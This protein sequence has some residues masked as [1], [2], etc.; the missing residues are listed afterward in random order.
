MEI[1]PNLCPESGNPKSHAQR[2]KEYYERLKAN[3]E[4][5][6]ARLDK[7]KLRSR[8]NR[9]IFRE[10][11]TEEE[12]EN[13]RRKNRERLQRWRQRKAQNAESERTFE[14]AK[15]LTQQDI[16]KLKQKREREKERRKAARAA[17]STQRRITERKKAMDRYYRRKS[18]NP[19]KKS[20]AQATLKEDKALPTRY[21]NRL[22][23]SYICGVLGDPRGI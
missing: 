7:Q 16:E 3:E 11:A 1:P 18:K 10:Q 8:I 4:L 17:W 20:R 13:R 22:L 15:P 14:K 23:T 19:S 21:V 12:K 5:Y 9:A 6:R 2:S